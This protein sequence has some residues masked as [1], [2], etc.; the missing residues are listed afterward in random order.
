MVRE[1]R[2]THN[3][4]GVRDG[5]WV[6]RGLRAVQ[7]Q[8]RQDLDIAALRRAKFDRKALGSRAGFGIWDDS[9]RFAAARNFHR[10]IG[11]VT[12]VKVQPDEAHLCENVE[13]RLAV[14]DAALLRPVPIIW[15]VMPFGDGDDAILM[16]GH[17]P[18]CLVVL[19]EP[20]NPCES[21]VWQGMPLDKVS[22]W[23]E[24][25]SSC[26]IGPVKTT[27]G[28]TCTFGDLIDPGQRFR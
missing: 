18:V 14:P 5:G 11:G 2:R 3:P 16:P 26:R 13:W 6:A 10:T 21:C 1:A 19:G 24:G 22:H 4:D 27:T 12:I 8:H 23:S 9:T 17:A 28:T 7:D 25:H 20:D 15:N